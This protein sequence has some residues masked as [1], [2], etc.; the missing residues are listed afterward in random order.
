[1]IP[2]RPPQIDRTQKSC[3]L[4]LK[5]SCPITNHVDGQKEGL[6]RIKLNGRTK[7]CEEDKNILPFN[8]LSIKQT[9]KFIK[10]KRGA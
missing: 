8:F 2:T 4:M 9:T 5:K 6:E 1:M 7:N 10:R 3:H